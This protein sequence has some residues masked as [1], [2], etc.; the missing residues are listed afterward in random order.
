M[1]EAI[2]IVCPECEKKINVPA[3]A[4]GKKIRCKGCEHVFVVQAAAA[5]RKS[6]P[7]LRRARPAGQDAGQGA[8]KK[9]P[10]RQ[11]RQSRRPAADD[12]EGR[13]SLRRHVAR[14]GAALPRLRQRDGERGRH[15]L[16]ALRLQHPDAH[17]R[18]ERGPSKTTHGHDVDPVAAARHPS[19]RCSSSSLLT[20]DIWY[21]FKIQRL[22]RST[23][24]TTGT[25]SSATP[26][27]HL[28]VWI[29]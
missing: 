11:G 23:T 17:A 9:A 3:E 20:F 2:T 1:A 12:E 19:A 28:V 16:P 18:L 21:S 10:R 13:Q 29:F 4:V 26:L 15:H 27:H 25:R 14:H 24:T 5:G 7:R 8:K 22:F 6:R